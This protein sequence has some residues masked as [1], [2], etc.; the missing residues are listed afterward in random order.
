M[1]AKVLKIIK[2][3]FTVV[4]VITNFLEW[5]IQLGTH[6]INIKQQ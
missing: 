3:N 6:L 2:L 5:L 1:F 4:E